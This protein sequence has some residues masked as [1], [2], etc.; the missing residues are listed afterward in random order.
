M[1][2][3]SSVF[4]APYRILSAIWHGYLNLL[5]TEYDSD[6]NVVSVFEP[7]PDLKGKRDIV[8][9]LRVCKQWLVWSNNHSSEF[10]DLY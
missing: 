1:D 2:V 8:S 9:R 10:D 7:S 5:N 4:Y 6:G 3:L